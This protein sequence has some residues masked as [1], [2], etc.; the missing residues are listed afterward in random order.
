MPGAYGDGPGPAQP[1]PAL[2]TVSPVNR[3]LTV[4]LAALCTALAAPATA[5]AALPKPRD[6]TI[7]VP[8]SIGGV[9]VKQGLKDADRAWGRTGAC[10]L[11]PGFKSCSYESGDPLK[12]RA[13]IDAAT[14]KRVSSFAIEA[15]RDEDGG[16]V[17]AGRLLRFET[18][19]GIGLGDKGGRV[20]KA[21]PDAIKTAGKTG[22]LI[23]GERRSYMT[24]Q[25]LGG[26]RIT[27]ITVFDGKHQG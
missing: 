20:P 11:S 15:G 3:P 12:G 4:V 22:Y 14:R 25:T 6:S 8:G 26:N 7:A 17:F 1:R 10:D 27:A 18:E 21:Y 24:F 5:L 23:E 9:A 19:D 13:W 2:V 16:Y